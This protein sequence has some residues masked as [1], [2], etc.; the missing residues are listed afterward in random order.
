MS[1]ALEGQMSAA[2]HALGIDPF[3]LRLRNTRRRGDEIAPRDTPADGD[4]AELLRRVAAEAGWDTPKPK[5][6]GRG[7]AFGMKANSPSVSGA[8]VHLAQDCTAI[9]YVGTSEMGQG[10]RDTARIIVA[11]LLDLPVESVS[12]VMS[13]TGAVPFDSWTAS[14]RSTVMMGRALMAACDDL[15]AQLSRHAA[16]YFGAESSD[17][18]TLRTGTVSNGHNSI[19][20]A[21]LL[22]VYSADGVTGNGT[23]SAVYDPQHPLGGPAPFF[24]VVAT[25]VELHID[26]ETGQVV[27]DKVVHGTDAGRVINTARARRIDEGGIL[28]GQSLALSE[29][30]VFGESGMLLNGSSLD[31]RISTIADFPAQ[32]SELYLENAD[33]P[34]P[35]GAK[36]VAEGGI[37]AI[38]PAI[39]GAILDLTGVHPTKIPITPERLWE[40]LNNEDQRAVPSRFIS[41]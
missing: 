9:A 36:G 20:L 33:G 15:R 5:G 11:E 4:W 6:R 3:E 18:F 7:I 30:L 31:Y 27:V 39:C 38:G 10:Q 19:A 24:L 14:S 16:G 17:G 12:V 22:R 37:L 26:V 40:A 8:R 13:D 34:G 28:M 21:Q 1:M 29:G 2:A 35:F 25:A 32:M 41:E 23:Y